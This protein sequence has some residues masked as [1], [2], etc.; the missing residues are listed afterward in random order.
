MIRS[1]ISCRK[2]LCCKILIKIHQGQEFNFEILFIRD[3]KPLGPSL[4]AS[5]RIRVLIDQTFGILI[6]L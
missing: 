5:S 6:N 3:V 2:S 1:V 4:S